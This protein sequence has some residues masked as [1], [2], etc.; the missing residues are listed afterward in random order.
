MVLCR[1][2]VSIVNDGRYTNMAST[3]GR[4]A[5][6]FRQRHSERR[7]ARLQQYTA[8]NAKTVE[9]N[10]ALFQSKPDDDTHTQRSSV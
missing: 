4:R 7:D 3:V 9:R 6:R 2:K 10:A 5:G 1:S 8:S